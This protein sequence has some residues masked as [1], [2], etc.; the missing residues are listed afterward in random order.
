MHLTQI[1]KLAG[2]VAVTAALAAAPATAVCAAEWQT[3]ESVSALTG[4]SDVSV[5]L[6]SAVPLS[7]MIG[8]PEA[9]TLVFR[10][11][12]GGL[13]A[14]VVWPQV[15]AVDATKEF[16]D[17]PQTMVLWRVD[18]TAIRANYWDRSTDGTA[19]GKFSTGGATKILAPLTSAHKLV[20]RMT[21]K[22]TQDAVFDLGDVAPVIAKIEQACGVSPHTS[23]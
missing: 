3:R 18:D 11:S 4:A 7:N 19:A 21:G 5:S 17:T 14:Y 15:L 10:C 8:S 12:G 6:S 16:V 9:A 22:T 1:L 20:V 23:R 13:S 2:H